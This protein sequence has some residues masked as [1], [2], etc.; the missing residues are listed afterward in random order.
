MSTQT[1]SSGSPV[2]RNRLLYGALW[3]AAAFGYA[4]LLAIGENLLA[5]TVFVGFGVAAG[6]VHH[7]SDERLFDERD[8]RVLNRASG[9][10]VRSL[11]LVSAVLFPTLVVLDA[12]GYWDWTP[13][14]AGIAVAVAVL[15]GVWFGTLLVVRSRR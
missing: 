12:L 1:A 9:L 6:L 5:V 7:R 11:G 4:G 15:Y 14:M 3:A 10:T 13:F 8:E 2:R